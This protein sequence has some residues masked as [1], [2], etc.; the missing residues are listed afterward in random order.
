MRCGVLIA[1]AGGSQRMGGVDKTVVPVAGRTAMQW[2]LAALAGVDRIEEIVIV[3]SERN[4]EGVRDL[5]ERCPPL[6]PARVARGGATRQ[7][8]VLAGLRELSSKIDLVLIHDAARILVTPD[9]IQRGIALGERWGA[10]VAA[11]PVTDTIKRVGLDDQVLETLDRSTLR[12]IQ[13]PQVFRRDWLE[14][15]YQK[16]EDTNLVFTDEA[17]LLEWAGY[18]VRVYPG[19]VENFKLTTPSDVALA[20]ALLAGRGRGGEA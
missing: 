19:A 16:C 13:T 20:A 11:V 3:A 17:G 8:S 1:A 5:L 6:V 4:R 10:A 15:A 14:A 18:P 7:E 2:V 9:L 12:A